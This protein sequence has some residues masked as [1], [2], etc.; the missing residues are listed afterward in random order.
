MYYP[1]SE[2]KQSSI[3]PM[4]GRT[5]RSVSLPHALSYPTHLIILSTSQDHPLLTS[6]WTVSSND[7]LDELNRNTTL[8]NITLNQWLANRTGA[9]V[10]SAGNQWGWL[11]LPDNS[12]IF[13]NTTDPSA[14]PTSAHYEFVFTV[15][16]FQS[17]SS[18]GC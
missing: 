6:V 1:L 17:A 7:T 13:E 14:G 18:H 11:R 2:S 15:S 9:D 3:S 10:L 12:S 8:Q 5:S 16:S 4:S